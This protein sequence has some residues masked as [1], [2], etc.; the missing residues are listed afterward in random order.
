MVILG[1]ALL[2]GLVVGALRPAPGTLAASAAVVMGVTH[3][4]L[5]AIAG[6]AE[7]RPDPA[8]WET[9]VTTV[10]H[11]MPIWVTAPAAAA[12]AWL[13]ARLRVRLKPEDSV[14]SAGA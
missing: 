4:I 8:A 11:D 14:W 12:A 2:I 9:V 13:A 10:A 5:L 1:I 3:L 6:M 7:G